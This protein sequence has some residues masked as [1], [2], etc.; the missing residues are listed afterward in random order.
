M[1]NFQQ[2]QTIRYFGESIYTRKGHI[3]EAEE[4]QIYLLKNQNLIIKLD[5]E[6][7]KVRIRK[8]IHLK[9]HEGRELT[10]NAFK[11][12]MFL[13]K[14]TQGEELKILTPKQKL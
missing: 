13:Q 5:Q 7:R 1:Y 9:V 3:V 14:T 11:D 6:E 2:N 10:L 8:Q 4:D 12:G